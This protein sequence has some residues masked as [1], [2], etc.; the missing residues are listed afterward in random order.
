M[1]CA[2]PLRSPAI[3]GFK[4]G[5]IPSRV[6]KVAPG[7]DFIVFIT[8]SPRFP[9]LASNAALAAPGIEASSPGRFTTD[10]T[11]PSPVFIKD[12]IKFAAVF[13]P[14]MT[15]LSFGEGVIHAPALLSP[16]P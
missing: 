1:D 8:V 9:W 7:K 3:A 10:F 15:G 2:T 13:T 12:G 16:F 6:C 5:N 4:N 11:I 14:A